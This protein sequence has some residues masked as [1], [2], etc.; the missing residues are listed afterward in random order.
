[1]TKLDR[2]NIINNDFSISGA[3]RDGI[4]LGMS[5]EKMILF[6]L[7]SFPIKGIICSTNNIAYDIPSTAYALKCGDRV[8]GNKIFD[9]VM[10][11]Q[12][13]VLCPKLCLNEDQFTVYGSSIF[14]GKSSICRAALL[15]KLYDDN[16]GGELFVSVGDPKS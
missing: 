2:N 14:S 11:S 6:K 9:G 15:Q 1:M 8:T 10:Y 7:G 4:G 16:I 13:K 5:K 3:V 12:I